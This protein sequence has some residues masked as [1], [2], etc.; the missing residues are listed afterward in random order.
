MIF[1]E[2][3]LEPVF[4]RRKERVFED[5]HVI[6][7]CLFGQIKLILQPRKIVKYI[8]FGQNIFI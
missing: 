3:Y 5:I 8:K 6:L 2:I 1:N 4:V 7:F